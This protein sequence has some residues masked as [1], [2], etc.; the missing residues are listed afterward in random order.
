MDD[1]SEVDLARR[2][3]IVTIASAADMLLN[4]PLWIVAKRASAGLPLPTLREMYKGSGSLYLAMGPMTVV[5][6][7][8]TTVMDRSLGR[9]GSFSKAAALA[10]AST[11]SG[12]AGALLVGAQVEAMI[13]RAHAL[14]CTVR[15]AGAVTCKKG[16]LRSLLIPPGLA[17]MAAREVRLP[18]KG[19]A[20]NSGSPHVRNTASKA[21]QP[22]A[23]SLRR[24]H[25]A[26]ASS[27]SPDSFVRNCVRPNRRA[28]PS[29]AGQVATTARPR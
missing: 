18:Q 3:G 6:D 11:A 24:H 13:T 7:G 20:G 17:M 21:S 2:A 12:V 25:I 28:H 27:F 1:R 23:K 29:S 4:F 16:G 9:T 22:T 10:C 8:A 26:V 14:G 19:A 5:E 15:E